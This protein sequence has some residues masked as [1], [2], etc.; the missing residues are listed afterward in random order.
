MI[1]KD[2]TVETEF[3]KVKTLVIHCDYCGR[4][5]MVNGAMDW[6]EIHRLDNDIPPIHYCS[7]NHLIKGTQ[8]LKDKGI[9]VLEQGSWSLINGT[10]SRAE[11]KD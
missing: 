9:N 6:L 5:H 4:K 7:L 11:G 2:Y 10:C 8:M 3:G 1:F